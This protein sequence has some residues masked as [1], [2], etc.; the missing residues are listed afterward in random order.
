M[1]ATGNLR[2]NGPVSLAVVFQEDD[3]QYPSV[4]EGG[5][6]PT[7]QIDSTT[8]IIIDPLLFLCRPRGQRRRAARIALPTK[9]V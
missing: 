6:S 1:I 9:L 8:F 4:F 2:E 7:L 3:Y 5:L